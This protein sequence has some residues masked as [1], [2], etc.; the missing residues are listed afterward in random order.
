M[1]RLHFERWA[2]AAAALS[3]AG[4][5][6]YFE[7]PSCHDHF[8]AGEIQHYVIDD[9]GVVLDQSTGTRWF[10]CQ[11]GE[12]SVAGQCVG[13][14]LELSQADAQQYAKE[15]SEA[16]GR[17]WRLPTVREMASLKQD[18]CHKPAINTR[19]FPSIQ[20]NNYWTSST[21]PNGRVFGCTSYTFN[22]HD[23]CR[24]PVGNARPFLLVLD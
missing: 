11:A 16:S 8:Q 9:R 23:F 4:C 15:F 10:Q 21:S 1:T 17:T 18:Q 3:L 14:A 13:R 5:E 2:L 24:E 20:V 6:R 12:Q 7:Q 19:V 22:G